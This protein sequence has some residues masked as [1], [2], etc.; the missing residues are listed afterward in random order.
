[1][2]KLKAKAGDRSTYVVTVGF[3]DEA[4][5]PVVPDSVKWT[6]SKADGTVVNQRDQVAAQPETS[7][8]IL[9]SGDDLDAAADGPVRVVTVEATYTSTLGAGLPLN[10]ACSF[11][12]ENLV[13]VPA[14]AAVP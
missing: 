8:E 1:M 10:A 11:S 5:A 14:P 9:L 13:R 3:F 4:G 6:L 2:V 12:V 7:L